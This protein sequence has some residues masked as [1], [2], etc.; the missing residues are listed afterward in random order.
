[1]ET[2]RDISPSKLSEKDKVT[3][4]HSSSPLR[5]AEKAP[6]ITAQDAF[7]K[8][9]TKRN[10]QNSQSKEQ[11]KS[12]DIQSNE[13]SNLIGNYN[14]NP[15]M[16]LGG[17]YSMGSPMGGFG[18]SPYMGG[19]GL[20]GI[21]M[22]IM[23]GALSNINQLLFSFQSV[24]FS[25]G[26]A[27][28]ILGM[29]TQALHQLYDQ[30]VSMIDQIL[31]LVNELKSLEGKDETKLT[32]EEQKRRRRLKAL[33]WGIVLSISY[34]GYSMVYK[35]LKRRRDWKKRRLLRASSMGSIE[36]G[37]MSPF[38]SNSSYSTPQ[39]YSGYYSSPS[40]YGGHFMQQQPQYGGYGS[41]Y[42]Y[43]STYPPS[44]HQSQ[45]LNGS[46]Y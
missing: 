1:M 32:Q 31:G 27:M 8:I 6:S 22:P 10:T 42:S 20:S 36:A 37:T 21:G 35:W 7:N 44:M 25:L 29:N 34:A 3:T 30:A 5:E 13:S 18:Y 23:G 43:G 38:V 14:I 11:I 4:K 33:R 19:M 24:I 2:N 46:Y 17:G 41:A 26:Q 45:Y 12:N 39:P 15:M 40:S 28:Q 16:G 9:L